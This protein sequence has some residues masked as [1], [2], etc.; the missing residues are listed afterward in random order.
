LTPVDTLFTLEKKIPT[1]KIVVKIGTNVITRESGLLNAV[2]V[3][4]L[5]EQIVTLKK[6]GI[7]VIVVSSG[8]MG[9]GRGIMHLN[10]RVDAVV[11]RQ[12]L[13]S[14]GQIKLMGT[15]LSSFQKHG[16]L[17][18]Q[19]LVT[20]EDFR[21]RTHYL[22]M[23]NCFEALLKSGVVPVVNE[24]DVVSVD[25]LM[26]TDN[27]ELAGLIASMMDV[28]MLVLLSTV[29][30]MYDHDPKEK[31]AQL[32]R[33]VDAETN[34]HSFVASTTSSFGRGGMLTKAKITK[35]LAAMGIPAI[36]ANGQRKNVLVDILDGKAMGTTFLKAKKKASGIKRWIGSNEGNEK[37]VVTINAGAEKKLRESIAS[38]L[39]VGMTKVEGHFQKGDMIKI[40]NETGAWVGYGIAVYRST[41]AKRWVGHK[42]KKAL[43]HYDY[44]F[45]KP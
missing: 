15:Y 42:N 19:V 5:V 28:D 43:I 34:V 25:E 6:K 2:V 40:Q 21:D 20:K 31:D 38:L 32:I 9:A 30:G 33:A 18:A 44:L 16:I 4:R 26:F 3:K 29:D 1:K 8:A 41:V 10:E 35:R 17:C 11:K 27:D 13:A 45:L 24:N 7:D 36:I 14:V 23:K 12:V 37:G 22:N 39:P